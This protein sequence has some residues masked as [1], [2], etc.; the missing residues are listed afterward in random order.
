MDM[1]IMKCEDGYR[2]NF[3][4]VEAFKTIQECI[5]FGKEIFRR[6]NEVDGDEVLDVDLN[7]DENGVLTMK[8]KCSFAEL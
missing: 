4:S 8:F 2:V 5:D 6:V 3:E 7:L 1:G